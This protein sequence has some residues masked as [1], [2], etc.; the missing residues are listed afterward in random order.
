MGYRGGGGYR[1][2]GGGGYGSRGGGGYGS[3]G[4]YGG[5]REPAEMHPVRCADCGVDTQVPFKPTQDRPVYCRDCY[6]KQRGGGGYG[7]RGGGGGFRGGGRGGYGGGGGFRGP[8]RPSPEAS[9]RVGEIHDVEIAEVGN[10]GDGIARVENFVIF[11]PGTQKGE[12]VKVR[13]RE[14]AQRFAVAEL[15]T[16]EAASGSEEPAGKPPARD[17]EGPAE[18]SEDGPDGTEE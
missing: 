9:V 14:V 2:R 12:R 16:G 1:G 4:G 7:G 6:Q 10:K 11:V 8:R 17:E 18:G 5:F 15:A 13:I 3:R